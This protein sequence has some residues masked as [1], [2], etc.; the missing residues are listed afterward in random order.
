MWPRGDVAT[1]PEGALVH[2]PATLPLRSASSAIDRWRDLEEL[3][4]DA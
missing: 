3:L 4:D 1:E 2:E